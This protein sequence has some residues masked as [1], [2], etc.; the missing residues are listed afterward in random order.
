MPNTTEE[1]L[2]PTL[3]DCPPKV[4]SG[5]SKSRPRPLR[6]T[7]RRAIRVVWSLHDGGTEAQL[8]MAALGRA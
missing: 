2:D 8:W 7:E 3:S 5:L 6:K 1:L 4:A